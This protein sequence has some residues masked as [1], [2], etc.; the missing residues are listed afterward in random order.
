[1]NAVPPLDNLGSVLTRATFLRVDLT[2]YSLLKQ[3]SIIREGE[4]RDM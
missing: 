1:M 3:L 4:A 2:P